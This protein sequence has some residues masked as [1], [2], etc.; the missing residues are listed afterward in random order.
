MPALPPRDLRYLRSNAQGADDLYI[1][2]LAQPAAPELLLKV[3]TLDLSPEVWSQDDRIVYSA[4]SPGWGLYVLSLN[5]PAQAARLSVANAQQFAAQLSPSM[6]WLTL[7]SEESGR[8]EVIAQTFPEAT[9]RVQVSANGGQDAKWRKDGRELFFVNTN[10]Q[11]M[12]VD[13]D[14]R[15]GHFGVPHVLFETYA[16]ESSGNPIIY[17]VSPDGQRFLMVQPSQGV[18]ANATKVIVNW[19]ALMR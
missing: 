18:G 6:R 17:D 5:Q 11:M 9:T 13:V 8:R 1:A 4:A 7:T 3:G 2:R 19:P 15:A 12:A 14:E 16:G 10:R